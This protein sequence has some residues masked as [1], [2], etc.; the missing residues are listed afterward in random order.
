MQLNQRY[1]LI[2]PNI[3]F[4]TLLLLIWQD[5]WKSTSEIIFFWPDIAASSQNGHFP[6]FSVLECWIGAISLM[7]IMTHTDSNNAN[8]QTWHLP[9]PP[10]RWTGSSW[11]IAMIQFT[12][13]EKETCTLVCRYSFVLLVL[14]FPKARQYLR[15]S[16]AILKNNK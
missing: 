14:Y 8:F 9:F 2:T 1:H 11:L 13:R 12:L 6:A 5:L 7:E 10:L 4:K 15:L 3:N 16:V